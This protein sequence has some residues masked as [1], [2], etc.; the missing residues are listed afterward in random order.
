MIMTA[1]TLIDQIQAIIEAELRTLDKKTLTNYVSIRRQVAA[2]ARAMWDKVAVAPRYAVEVGAIRYVDR[3]EAF[4]YGR[5]AK[6]EGEIKGLARRGML[7]DISNLQYHGMRVYELEHNGMA[8]VYNQA[9]G[10]PITGGVKVPL[11]AQAVYSDF[12]GRS[13]IGTLQ[14]N[15]AAY[16]DDIIALAHRELNQGASYSQI[17]REI[18]SLTDRSYSSSLRVAATE[19]HRIQTMAFEDSLGLLDDVG[20]DYGKMWVASLDSKT[21]EDHQSMDGVEADGDGIFTLPDGSA[22]PGPGLTG[23]ASQDINCRCTA[24]AIINGQK[25]TERRIRGEGIVPYKTYA[26]KFGNVTIT[27]LRKYKP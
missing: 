8:W 1:Q 16:A 11:V 17:A 4:K 22:G 13:F 2:A 27:E 3:S 9:Y 14:K 12:S 24:V 21:R 7:T 19:T 25:P 23:E 5:M 10:L 15:W 18:V 6:L 20:A 26:E